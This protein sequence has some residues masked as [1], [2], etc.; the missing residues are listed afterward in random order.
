MAITEQRGPFRTVL[1]T[2]YCDGPVRGLAFD[3]DSVYYFELLGSDKD[4][5]KRLYAMTEI[6]FDLGVEVLEGFEAFE[7]PRYPL[8]APNWGG[9]EEFTKAGLELV[10][11]LNECRDS[12]RTWLLVEGHDLVG[13][14]LRIATLTGS[15]QEKVGALLKSEARLHVS[16]EPLIEDLLSH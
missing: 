4:D 8:W 7:E 12:A 6:E 2:D 15:E 13:G 14:E 5:L 9:S 16:D 11:R 1:V 3:E 10:A